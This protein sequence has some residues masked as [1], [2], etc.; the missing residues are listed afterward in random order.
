MLTVRRDGE[1]NEAGHL[2]DVVRDDADDEGDAA[3]VDAVAR[4]DVDERDVR[5]KS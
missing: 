5:A 1:L 4:H 3:Q 2:P